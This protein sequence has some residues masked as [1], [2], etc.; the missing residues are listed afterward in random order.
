MNDHGHDVLDV[1]P[2]LSYRQVLTLSLVVHRRLTYREI[3]A[4]LGTTERETLADIR[5]GLHNVRALL[6]TVVTS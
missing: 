5:D 1:V 6:A 2:A 3:A 4:R